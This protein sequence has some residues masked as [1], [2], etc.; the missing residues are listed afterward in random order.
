[1]MNPITFRD[2]TLTK[3]EAELLLKTLKEAREEKR[4]SE[5]IQENEKYLEEIAESM[6]DAIGVDETKRIFRKITRTLR[7]ITED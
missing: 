6:I 2:Y 5:A 4:K 7:G 1:M 3:D